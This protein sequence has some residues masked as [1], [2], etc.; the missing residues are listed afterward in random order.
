MILDRFVIRQNDSR[1][2]R[3]AKSAAWLYWLG[4]TV[5]LLGALLPSQQ[6][7]NH[8]AV[9]LLVAGGFLSSLCLII[10]PWD[11]FSANLFYVMSA[12]AC[13]HIATLIYFSGGVESSYGELYFLIAIWAAYFF[14]FKGFAAVASMTMVSYLVPFWYDSAYDINH[15]TS[16]LIHM[17]F[18]LIAGG[19][20]NLLVA[21]VRQR[22]IDLSNINE[23]LALKMREVLREKEKS[24]AV[25]ASVADGVYV[26]DNAGEIVLWNKSAEIITGFE[27]DEMLGREC[28][29][30]SSVTDGDE[31]QC[32]SMCGT[33]ASMEEGAASVGYEVLACRKDGDKIWLSVSA[34]PIREAGEV[35]GIVHVFRDISEYKQ[36]DRMKSD[37]VATVSHE[38]RTP[39]T[40]I[41][42]F[43]K[44]LLRSDTNFPDASRES[45][46]LEIVREG[47]RLAR[48]IEDVLSVSRIEAGSLRLDLKPV[49]AA[50]AVQHVVTN[51]SR[52]TSIHNFVIN[53]PDGMRQVQADPDKLHQVLLNLIVNAI[54]YS[55]DGG[56]IIVSAEDGDE[57]ILFSVSDEGVG[58]SPEHIPHVFERFYR[59]AR[60]RG[61]VAGTGLGLYVSKSLV[62][63]MGGRIW[64][65]S[66][67]GEGSRFFFELPVARA[68]KELSEKIAS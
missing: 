63:E 39:L 62:E 66:T 51:V 42:G 29:T 18:L 64:A 32:T 67:V 13:S 16:G 12:M 38:L 53:V 60:P 3:M 33:A 27:E 9:Y 25:L 14:D 43:S 2:A 68:D 47:E 56:P 19:L 59:A 30:A 36:I 8:E 45:F 48:L 44:T 1:Q 61:G 57:V 46:L 11:R 7:I 22:N 35:V 50:P 20:V 24:H 58:I 4:V 21:Q 23:R 52:L 54:K 28:F 26:V 17:L 15:V 34:A 55:P 49:E 40:S 5:V 6:E 37:F 41:L 31:A 10:I 65:E